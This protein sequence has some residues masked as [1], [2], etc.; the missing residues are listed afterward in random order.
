MNTKKNFTESEIIKMMEDQAGVHL[1]NGIFVWDALTIIERKNKEMFEMKMQ[2]LSSSLATARPRLDM[3]QIFS[4]ELKEGEAG[5][6]PGRIAGL[7][8][9]CNGTMYGDY[10]KIKNNPATIDDVLRAMNELL[11]KMVLAMKNLESN[12]K[13]ENPFPKERKGE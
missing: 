1:G 8:F 12:P 7:K 11:G 2:D 13:S 5:E 3:V 6:G 9:V 10:L 4:K